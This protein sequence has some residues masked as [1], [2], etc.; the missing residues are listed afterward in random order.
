MCDC[1]PVDEPSYLRGSSR[2]LM[3]AG[4]RL[5]VTTTDGHPVAEAPVADISRIEAFDRETT[6][7]VYL[8]FVPADLDFDGSRPSRHPYAVDV[9]HDNAAQV[10]AFAD[11]LT[12]ACL[13]QRRI[14]VAIETP[15][16]AG[17]GGDGRRDDIAAAADRLDRTGFDAA[18]LSRD[19]AALP[20]YLH[21]GEAVLEL[22][23]LRES[24]GQ[25]LLV[26]TTARL[27]V[28]S[29]DTGFVREAALQGMVC[30]RAVTDG[31]TRLVYDNGVRT[32]Y[33]PGGSSADLARLAE[34]GNT[35]IDAIVRN[36][37]L[38]PVQPSPTVL[39]A[40]YELIVERRQLRMLD[41]DVFRDELLGVFGALPS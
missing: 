30:L 36:G 14:E 35:V 12:R 22:A 15:G 25:T 28:L 2:S 24:D 4:D 11:A 31:T 41:T 20:H 1:C 38:R 39:F 34:R 29:L 6:I 17:P 8:W 5:Y 16:T 10:R 7:R 33:F 23:L 37:T 19:L 26:L 3:L 40:E 32:L 13:A 27:I 18:A 9:G 21:T